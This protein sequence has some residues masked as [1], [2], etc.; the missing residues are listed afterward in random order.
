M[1]TLKIEFVN[2]DILPIII[3]KLKTMGNDLV[4]LMREKLEEEFPK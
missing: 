3:E 2:S 1:E 4:D